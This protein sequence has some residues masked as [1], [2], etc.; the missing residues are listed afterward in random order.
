MYLVVFYVGE[1]VYRVSH[2]T[3]DSLYVYKIEKF[4]TLS[5]GIIITGSASASGIDMVH[6]SKIFFLK[7]SKNH[8][9][10]IAVIAVCD[11]CSDDFDHCDNYKSDNCNSN[12]CDSNIN[13]YDC[14]DCDNC[15]DSSD[16]SD[17]SDSK[18]CDSDNCDT[19]D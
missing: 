18:D 6:F 9:C 5:A 15:N 2:N 16:S 14:N 1:Y 17:S 7:N 11:S 4:R 19:N 3:W 12:Y 10:L 8:S 13:C